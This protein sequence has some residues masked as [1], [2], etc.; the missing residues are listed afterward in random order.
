MKPETN[1]LSSPDKENTDQ[2]VQQVDDKL[3][4]TPEK[5][6]NTDSTAVK[7]DPPV[8]LSPEQKMKIDDNRLKAVGKLLEKQTSGLCRD[9]GV[10]WLKVLEAEFKKPYF[11]KVQF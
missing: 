2:N 10:S 3:N 7:E 4:S 8:K 9:V 5:E 11:Q 6:Q 1:T